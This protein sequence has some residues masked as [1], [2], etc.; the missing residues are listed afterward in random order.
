MMRLR[1]RRDWL[2]LEGGNW[3]H[4][5]PKL[6]FFGIKGNKL[7]WRVWWHAEFHSHAWQAHKCNFNVAKAEGELC[8]RCAQKGGKW[9]L[10]KHDVHE[11]KRKRTNVQP[12]PGS[13]SCR[14][15]CGC[16]PFSIGVQALQRQSY[17][18]WIWMGSVPTHV[19][20]H[21]LSFRSPDSHS[22][23]PYLEVSFSRNKQESPESLQPSDKN[24]HPWWVDVSLCITICG[25]CTC[26]IIHQILYKKGNIYIYRETKIA[27]ACVRASVQVVLYL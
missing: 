18:M 10:S 8:T 14:N 24:T 22:H 4:S 5:R 25:W 9:A 19:Y 27:S 11:Q 26:Y 13:V 3:C 1:R 15:G 17:R 23:L 2:L 6:L 12:W 7:P 16:F 20:T 21:T